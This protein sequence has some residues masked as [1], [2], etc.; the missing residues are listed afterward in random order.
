MLLF[1]GYSGFYLSD[2]WML[3]TKNTWTVIAESANPPVVV[4][5]RR[6]GSG[7]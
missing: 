1:A 5:P 3:D 7:H 4:P 2:L 6:R